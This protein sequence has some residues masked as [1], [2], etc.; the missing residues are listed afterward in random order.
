[1]KRTGEHKNCFLCYN[2]SYDKTDEQRRKIIETTTNG[3]A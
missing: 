3:Y 2:K 1:M